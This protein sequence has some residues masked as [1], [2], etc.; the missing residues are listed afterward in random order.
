MTMTMTMNMAM[1]ML[2][3]WLSMPVSMLQLFKVRDVFQLM[4]QI[5]FLPKTIKKGS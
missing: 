2:L 3:L 4:I 5:V 1:K